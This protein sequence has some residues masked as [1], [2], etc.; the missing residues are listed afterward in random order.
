M[1]TKLTALL[2]AA[3]IAGGCGYAIAQGGG[4]SSGGGAG[5]A[6]AAPK[7]ESA[8]GGP[9]GQQGGMKV[10]KTSHK[11]KKTHRHM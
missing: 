10:R 3:L 7:A 4:G 11:K 6:N 2:T 9:A 1:R 5:G 8:P